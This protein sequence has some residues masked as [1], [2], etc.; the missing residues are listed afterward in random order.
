MTTSIVSVDLAIAIPTLVGSLLS[1]I[2]TVFIIATYIIMPPK[3]SHI[4]HALICNLAAAEFC[5]HLGNSISG[6]TI[7]ALGRD[8]E[9]GPGCVASGFLTQ[10]CVQ[11]V[12]CNM[13]VISV[14]LFYIV[15]H[16]FTLIKLPLKNT[17]LLAIAPWVLPIITSFTALANHYYH[18]VSGNWC[19][20]QAKPKY[21]RYIFTHGWRFF[22]IITVVAIG[23]RIRFYLR[24]SV[25]ESQGESRLTLRTLP[26]TMGHGNSLY[27]ERLP[28]TP[29][30]TL[31]IQLYPR[32]PLPESWE[33]LELTETLSAAKDHESTTHLEHLIEPA[34]PEDSLTT[35]EKQNIMLLSG[36][37]LF[38]IVL[39]LPGIANRV[40]EST[41]H[42]VRIL[43]ILQASTG[44]IGFANAATFGWNEVRNRFSI[45]QLLEMLLGFMLGN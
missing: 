4:R 10:L 45:H 1:T 11:A 29:D 40:A 41:G 8:L 31:S 36:Y 3:R 24:K 26:A 44:Y 6:L 25:L 14:T 33:A 23:V 21:L 13:L 37:P 9:D 42:S 38:Y 15:T 17:I 7:I 18:P 34:R 30:D 2:G 39:W 35:N 32:R 22:I 43:K 28:D 5:L 12:D 27:T 19:W 20:I 16:K